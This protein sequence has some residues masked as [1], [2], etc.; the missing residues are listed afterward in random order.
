M[1]NRMLNLRR[2][3]AFSYAQH[4][5]SMM[6]KISKK[7]SIN[8]KITDKIWS[9][10]EKDINLQREIKLVLSRYDTVRSKSDL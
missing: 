4:L 10:S 1:T 6:I 9:S 3:L 5:P 8:A 7:E 2:M